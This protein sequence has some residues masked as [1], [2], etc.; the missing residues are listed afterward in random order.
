MARCSLEVIDEEL[1]TPPE[2]YET[3]GLETIEVFNYL[4]NLQGE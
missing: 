2:H 4:R 1:H 3:L